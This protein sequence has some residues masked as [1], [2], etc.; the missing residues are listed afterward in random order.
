MRQLNMNL[1]SNNYIFPVCFG[2]T[3]GRVKF[4][5]NF[6]P[7]MSSIRETNPEYQA[8]YAVENDL[9]YCWGGS[10]RTMV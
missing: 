4:H 5:I 7:Y 6:D 9:D 3:P 1:I 2:E 10:S 8:F